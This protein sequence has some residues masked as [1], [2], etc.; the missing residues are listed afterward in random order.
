MQVILNLLNIQCCPD[1]KL[2]IWSIFTFCNHQCSIWWTSAGNNSYVVPTCLIYS[3]Q[4]QH[5]YTGN[6]LHNSVCLAPRGSNTNSRSHISN[7]FN[8]DSIPGWYVFIIQ[9]RYPG[10]DVDMV[11][12]PGV[13]YRQQP[14]SRILF[15]FSQRRPTLSTWSPPQSHQRSQSAKYEKVDNCLEMFDCEPQSGRTGTILESDAVLE[16]TSFNEHS[17]SSHNVCYLLPSALLQTI[18]S[19][20]TQPLPLATSLCNGQWSPGTFKFIFELVSS[21]AEPA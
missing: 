8:L 18:V 11:V 17:S 20:R 15:C 21:S 13:I 4:R 3:F 12:C 7:L 1:W 19:L 14:L 5:C 6:D 9:D 2:S 16:R 10:P